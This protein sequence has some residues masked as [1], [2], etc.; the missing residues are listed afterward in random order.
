MYV[1][2]AKIFLYVSAFTVGGGAAMIPV[3]HR[4]LVEKHALL[5]EDEFLDALGVAQS[6]PGVLGCNISIIAGYK[7]AG[8][9]GACISVISAMLPAFVS[10][11]IISYFFQGLNAQPAVQKFF[12]AV[13]PAVVAVLATAVVLLAEKSKLHSKQYLLSILVVVCVSFLHI[14]PFVV[15]LVIGLIH[16]VLLAKYQSN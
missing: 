7:I 10:I 5:T 3:L 16:V 14:S 1:L 4:E 11:L 2:L 15:I 8:V 9:A 6:T 13:K 12:V